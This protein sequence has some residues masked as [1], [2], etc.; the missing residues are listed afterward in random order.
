MKYILYCLAFFILLG[1]ILGRIK[2]PEPDPIQYSGDNPPPDPHRIVI[3]YD[4]NLGRYIYE[5]EMNDLIKTW[6]GYVLKSEYIKPEIDSTPIE[7]EDLP[8]DPEEHEYDGR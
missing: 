3:D 6:K 5:D 8:E 7:W 1:L 2:A 4:W